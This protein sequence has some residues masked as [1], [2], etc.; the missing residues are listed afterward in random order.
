MSIIQLRPHPVL[1]AASDQ[2]RLTF[3]DPEP[4]HG[5]DSPTSAYIS[6]VDGIQYE[7]KRGPREH[8]LLWPSLKEKDT[9]NQV[10]RQETAEQVAYA[11]THR[12]VLLERANGSPSARTVT[13]SQLLWSISES[14]VYLTITEMPLYISKIESTVLPL[15]QEDGTDADES[16]RWKPEDI[17]EGT[18]LGV[19][20]FGPAS[21]DVGSGLRNILL[22]SG[23]ICANL[24]ESK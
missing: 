2:I 23:M 6:C 3:G 7:S 17:D 8:M 5:P 11:Y 19:W 22:V 16:A 14:Q 20:E 4:I 12:E 18:M 24:Q 9:V 15:A 13:A 10:R 1:T 21:L